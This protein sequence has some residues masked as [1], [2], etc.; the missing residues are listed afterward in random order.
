[1]LDQLHFTENAIFDKVRKPGEPYQSA[2]LSFHAGIEARK[3]C[4][5]G[6][7]KTT[8]VV[9]QGGCPS[10]GEFSCLQSLIINSTLS[11]NSLLTSTR[12]ARS[13]LVPSQ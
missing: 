7:H 2:E 5:G 6:T 12:L 13:C 4:S 9:S 8:G 3:Y 10:Q 11:V 1:V